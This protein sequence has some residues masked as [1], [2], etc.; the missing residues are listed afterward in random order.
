M[1]ARKRPTSAEGMAGASTPWD[2]IAVN[3]TSVSLPPLMRSP[4]MVG[5]TKN[6]HIQPLFS[7]F[8]MFKFAYLEN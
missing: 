5:L 1:S 6:F 7:L 2:P 4:V 8:Q 3:A